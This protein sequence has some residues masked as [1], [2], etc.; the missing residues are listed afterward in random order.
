[1]LQFAAIPRT[2]LAC[3]LTNHWKCLVVEVT[4]VK[5][6]R[7]THRQRFLTRDNIY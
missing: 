4:D 2:N 6:L 7:K 1:M 5:L 3:E